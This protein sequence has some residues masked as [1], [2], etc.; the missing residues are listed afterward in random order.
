MQFSTRTSLVLIMLCEFR[1]RVLERVYLCIS[2][3]SSPEPNHL[4]SHVKS[5]AAGFKEFRVQGFT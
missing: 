5:E 1:K 2:E 3:S 4:E